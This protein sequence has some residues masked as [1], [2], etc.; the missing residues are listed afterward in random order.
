MIPD[1][2]LGGPAD[3]A[4]RI[5]R[6]HSSAAF[7]HLLLVLAWRDI[8]VRYKQSLLGIGWAVLHPLSMMLIFTFVFTRAFP[9]SAAFAGGIPYPLY[10]YSGLV[11]WTLLAGGLSGCV[12]SLVGNRNL[13]TKVYFAREVLPLSCLASSLA[14]CLIA[15]TV[16]FGLMGYYH[17]SGEYSF[18]VR[19][20]VLL[21]PLVLCIQLALVAG[22]GML[23]AMANL[24]YRDVRQVVG[25]AVQLWMFISGVVVPVPGDGSLF[26]AF[27]RLNPMVAVIAAYRACLFDGDR[28]DMF[29]LAIAAAQAATILAG[30]WVLFRKASHRFAECI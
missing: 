28:L 5:E 20:T 25:V 19:I 1:I 16:L 7:T 4:R 23:L 6:G 3:S 11:P 2:A 14:D 15:G 30:G 8:R 13:V 22:L 26:S 10:V 12:M 17:L 29:G 24:F 9:G 21:L 18:S 27:V